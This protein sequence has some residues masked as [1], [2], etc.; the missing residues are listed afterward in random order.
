MSDWKLTISPGFS[1]VYRESARH[2]GIASSGFT[3]W[4]WN[5]SLRGNQYGY[6]TPEEKAGRPKTLEGVSSAEELAANVIIPDAI[7]VNEFLDDEYNAAVVY[8]LGDIETPFLSVANLVSHSLEGNNVSI[9]GDL[10]TVLLN[11]AAWVFICEETSSPSCTRAPNLS[12]FNSSQ[13]DTTC[14]FTIHTR[15]RTSARSSTPS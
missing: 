5:N 9:S 10:T 1:D 13:A 15:W 4:W 11:R 14:P 6:P 7:A 12:T 8:D 3:T 2:G